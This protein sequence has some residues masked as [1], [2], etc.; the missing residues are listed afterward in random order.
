MRQA[1]LPIRPRARKP[2]HSVAQILRW[3]D[4][5]HTTHG[6]WPTSDDGIVAGTADETWNAIDAALARGNRGLP[7]GT[8]LAKLLLAKRAR[9]HHNLPPDLTIPLILKWADAHY[10]RTGEWPDAHDTTPIPKAPPQSSWTSIHSALFRGIRGLPGGDSLPRLL[11]RHRGVRNHLSLPD[12]TETRILAWADDHHTR[13]GRYPKHNSGPVPAAPGET[14][15]AVENALIKGH[16]GLPGGESLA[17]LLTRCR[18]VRNKADAP[19]LTVR[20]IKIWAVAHKERTGK[21]PTAHAGPIADA[22]GETWTAVHSALETGLRG[23]PGGDSLARLLAREC[24]RRNLA[25]LPPLTVEKIREWVRL[26]HAHTGVWPK[27]LSGPIAGV[28]GETWGA[29]ANALVKGRRGLPG[30]MSLTQ[31]VRECQGQ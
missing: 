8:T 19:L 3:C 1:R 16:R 18:G 26:H 27:A 2:R 17:K 14:W 21:W 25:D 7:G 13:T 29:M 22:P 11:E 6:R 31:V 12:L 20:Q 23:L 15:T 30:G 5:F 24:G 4:E 9:P 28:P 10:R